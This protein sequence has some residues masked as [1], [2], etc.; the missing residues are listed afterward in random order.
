MSL[1]DLKVFN[2]DVEEKAHIKRDSKGNFS[3]SGGCL[4]SKSA[5]E[6]YVDYVLFDESSRGTIKLGGQRDYNFNNLIKLSGELSER[7]KGDW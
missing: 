1:T 5:A 6:R 4:L 7:I 3:I 2:A